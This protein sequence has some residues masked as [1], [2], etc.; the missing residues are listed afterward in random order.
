MSSRWRHPTLLVLAS[1]LYLIGSCDPTTPEV[2]VAALLADGRA[3]FENFYFYDAKDAFAK[4]VA[5]EPD[6][7][8]ASFAL[9]RTLM[10]LH[11]YEEAIPAFEVAISLAP[12][13]P[14]VH[15]G[16][17]HALVWGGVL[18]GR[19]DWL[20]GALE[21]SADAVGRFPALAPVYEN[22]E[23]A[24]R[25]TNALAAWSELLAA[26]EPTVGESPVF[27]V[28]YLS[29]QLMLARSREEPQTEAAV[30]ASLRTLLTEAEAAAAAAVGS[31]E[32]LAAATY[33]LAHG[34]ALLEETPTSRQWLDRLE[35]TEPGRRLGASM[36]HFG[37]FRLLM[38]KREDPDAAWEL[39]DAWERRFPTSW[40]SN[41]FGRAGVVMGQRLSMLWMEMRSRR[42]DDGSLRAPA[43][44][45]S[46]TDVELADAAVALTERYGRLSTGSGGGLYVI[47]G[48]E[49]LRLGVR[50][51]EALRLAE[52]LRSRIDAGEH[53]F[54]PGTAPGELDAQRKNLLAACEHV[55]G[56][57]LHRLGRVAEAEEALRAAI[58]Y[59]ERADKYAALGEFLVVE[60]RD[61]EGYEALVDALGW[62][63]VS[64]RLEDEESVREQAIAILVSHGEAPVEL[65]SNVVAAEERARV[66][67]RARI[68]D[69]KLEEPAPDFALT[70]LDGNEWRLSDLTGKVVVLNYWATWCGPCRTEFPYYDKLVQEYAGDDGIVF[71]AISTDANRTDVR[72]FISEA[73]YEFTVLYDEGSATDFHVTGIPIHFVLG[74]EGRIQYRGMGFPGPDRYAREM[75]WR[76][77]ELRVR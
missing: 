64:G 36:R 23:F 60:G 29:A 46:M 27:R 73:E 13:N 74:P 49:L 55:R 19:R 53:V 4:A 76:I 54:Y 9:A 24:A 21:E 61:W 7:A 52:R 17:V 26:L 75:K 42:T 38:D 58:R 63:A 28:H 67:F 39:L 44:I 12:A 48:R 47:T 2:N 25:E 6:D 45:A 14:R 35:E 40:D 31:A 34:Y 65:E 18:R 51:E 15:E 30:L 56:Q 57:A 1:S 71:L 10:T 5:A 20:D 33:A 66:A 16:Y 11:E 62:E 37:F 8:A 41:D 70:D 50:E 32:D 68:V 22:M 72:E 3:S 69:D 43:I 59:E 77:E